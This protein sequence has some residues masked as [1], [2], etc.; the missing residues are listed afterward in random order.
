MIVRELMTE[1]PANVLP[2]STIAGALSLLETLDVRLVPVV[3]GDG[4]LLGVV[5]DR[6]LGAIV[7][8]YPT[9]DAAFVERLHWPISRAMNTAVVT[10]D[11]DS[12]AT[13]AIEVMLEQHV[14]AVPVI[15][16]DGAFVGLVSYV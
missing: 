4:S 6:E 11:A 8:P 7:G 14:A 9:L 16:A 10:V 3:D 1:N 5:S 2:S 13:D 15:D 12:E